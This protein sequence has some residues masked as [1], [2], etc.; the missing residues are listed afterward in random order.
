MLR[1]PWL[2]VLLPIYNGAA[3]LDE[4]LASLTD[5]ADG[6]EIIAVDQGST[7]ASADILL[8]HSSILDLRVIDAPG[9]TN[10]VQNTN[11]AL[12]RANAPHATLLHQDD[13][14]LPGRAALLKGMLAQHPDAPLWLHSAYYIND[15]G[16]RVGR[17]APPFGRKPRLLSSRY[18]L[19]RLLVQNTLALPAAMFSTQQARNLDGLDETL[20]YTADW[21]FWLKLSATGPVAWDPADG[22]AFRIHGAAQTLTGSRDLTDFEVQLTEPLARYA[23]ALPGSADVR[24]LAHASNTL[25]VW[26]AA[27]YHGERRP[28]GPLLATLIRL[29]PRLW[30]PFL[31]D[32]RIMQR[33]WARMPQYRNRR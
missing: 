23:T 13:L 32:T 29:G 19:S 14:W 1:D 4:T 6:V 9:N 25:N 33:I 5:Q 3:T 31:R 2:S 21:D 26:L 27:A 17:F 16:K 11:L 28:L 20:W 8:G 30:W 22:A 18:A 15:K 7:D 12:S 10:W 24:R